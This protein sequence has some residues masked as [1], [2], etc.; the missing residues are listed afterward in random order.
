MKKE[1]IC[2]IAG[3]G[4]WVLRGTKA[5]EIMDSLSSRPAENEI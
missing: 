3:D 1:P 5:G 4:S 2:V